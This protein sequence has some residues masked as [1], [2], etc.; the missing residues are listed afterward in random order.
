MS[1]SARH[2]NSQVQNR[3]QNRPNIAS[4]EIRHNKSP[5]IYLQHTCIMLSAVLRFS[6]G[7]D[8][9]YSTLSETTLWGFITVAYNSDWRN[10]W[11]GERGEMGKVFCFGLRQKH[12]DEGQSQDCGK[13]KNGTNMVLFQRDS[14]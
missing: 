6:S 11:M 2:P 7:G 3:H 10:I 1:L 14:K 12:L 9:S 8:M 5:C 13:E 4:D